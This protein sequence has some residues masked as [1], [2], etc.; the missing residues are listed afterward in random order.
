MQAWYRARFPILGSCWF[1]TSLGPLPGHVSVGAMSAGRCHGGSGQFCN[2]FNCFVFLN[3]PFEEVKPVITF[4]STGKQFFSFFTRRPPKTAYSDKTK[5]QK[6]HVCIA[7]TNALYFRS[8][9][10]CG[11]LT[12][13]QRLGHLGQ[14]SS[15]CRGRRQK[16]MGDGYTAASLLV[17][18]IFCSFT[19]CVHCRLNF[20]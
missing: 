18:F 3:L 16:D 5:R 2:C 4:V 17:R 9:L 13:H 14:H 19:C 15:S 6:M 12:A 1:Q 7:K 10:I 11:C 20:C 8:L